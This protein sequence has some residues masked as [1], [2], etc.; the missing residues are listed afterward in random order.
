MRPRGAA[1][2]NVLRVGMPLTQLH[3]VGQRARPRGQFACHRRR[4]NNPVVNETYPHLHSAAVSAVAANRPRLLEGD[5]PWP[6][7]K[8]GS[9]H[10]P[11]V[12]GHL[13]FRWPADWQIG[14]HQPAD[15]GCR[16]DG[17]TLVV[18]GR[19]RHKPTA[20]HSNP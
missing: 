6:V 7:Y 2:V 8:Y 17:L 18:P 19:R 13:T 4:G 5:D 12:A 15:F 1:R 9:T 20:R 3:G 10:R 11:R 14:Q 16:Y